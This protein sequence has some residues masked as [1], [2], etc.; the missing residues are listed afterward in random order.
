MPKNLV[1]CNLR[2]YMDRK[3]WSYTYVALRM[4]VTRGTI[5]NWAVGRRAP[6]IATATQ[7]AKLVGC[8]VQ[9]LWPGG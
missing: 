9:K 6:S 3:G 1:K 7:L 8:T 2:R 5:I 4:G